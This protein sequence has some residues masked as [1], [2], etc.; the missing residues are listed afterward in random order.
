MIYPYYLGL[1]LAFSYFSIL[2][3]PF[4][5]EDD[6][7]QPSVLASMLFFFPLVG[8]FLG[9]LTVMVYALLSDLSW[10]G[11][12]ISALLYMMFYGFLH[13]E[14]VIDVADAVYA[15][16]GNKDGYA[17][18]KDPTVGAMGVLYAVAVVLLK[19]SGLV[20][21]LVHDL[22]LAFIA[23]LI[24]SRLSLLVLFRVHDFRSSFATQLKEAFTLSYF[25]CAILLFSVFGSLI[26]PSFLILLSLAIV[27]ALGFSYTLKSKLGFVNGD[28]L[29]ATLEAVELSLF[30]I[31]AL[32]W[33]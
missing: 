18:I 25:I 21:L 12:I 14:A 11:A 17:I 33:I 31:V 29:G 20:F 22:V 24:V 32:V 6:L 10:Y 15:S 7:S 5:K 1:K 2:P 23:V 8:L 4:R 27:L 19:V 9:V 3:M 13:T 28:V 26:L 30:I 16:H